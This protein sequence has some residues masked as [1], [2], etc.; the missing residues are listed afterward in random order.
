[1]PSGL[2]GLNAE[3]IVVVTLT[4][5]VCGVV[6]VADSEGREKRDVSPPRIVSGLVG[7]SVRPME[8]RNPDTQ[9]HCPSCRRPFEELFTK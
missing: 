5:D 8:A 7:S 9:R 1:M 6:A 4:L 2:S 3:V